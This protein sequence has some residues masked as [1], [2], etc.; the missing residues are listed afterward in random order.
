MEEKENGIKG[1]IL[2]IKFRKWFYRVGIAAGALLAAYGLVSQELLGLWGVLFS[3]LL[4][5]ADV[6]A[7]YRGV[8][9]D[10]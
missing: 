3:A 4:G 2:D 5:L 8:E 1:Q 10:E 7:G 6:N 9:G